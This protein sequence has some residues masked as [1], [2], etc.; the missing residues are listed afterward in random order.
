MS[1]I[2]EFLRRAAQRRANR[3]TP[4]IE[5]IEPV[6]PVEVE[7]VE[8]EP[9]MEGVAQHVSRHMAPAGF[10]QR[11]SGFAQAVGQADEKVE[12]HLA[13]VFDHQV[14]QLDKSEGFVGDTPIVEGTNQVESAA[15]NFA[16]QLSNPQSIRHAILM[17]EILQRPEHRW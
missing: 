4:D 3:P 16:R 14:G 1:E 12:Q 8:A 9:V 7:I 13:S 6:Q 10:D 2:E 5:I 17:A 15:A 11:T